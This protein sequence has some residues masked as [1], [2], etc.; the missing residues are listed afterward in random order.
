MKLTV[1]IKRSQ[2]FP[3]ILGKLSILEMGEVVH[4]FPPPPPPKHK[5]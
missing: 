4:S 1:K 2:D 5:N 3:K